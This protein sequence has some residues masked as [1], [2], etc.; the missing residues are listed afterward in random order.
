MAT[1]MDV[2]ASFDYAVIVSSDN[3]VSALQALMREVKRMNDGLEYLSKYTTE[4]I[5][6]KLE[7]I[8]TE[9]TAAKSD[10][11]IVSDKTDMIHLLNLGPAVS[12]LGK[13]SQS[14]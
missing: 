3:A 5:N 9:V 6:K 14:S 8:D 7:I 10:V 2:A 11:K 1:A 13:E 4:V 12:E